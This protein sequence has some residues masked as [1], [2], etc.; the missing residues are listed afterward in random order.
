MQVKRLK[1]A[2]EC[3]ALLL[4]L[5][6]KAVKVWKD[7]GGLSGSPCLL[8]LFQEGW[9]LVDYSDEAISI[10]LVLQTLK[11]FLSLRKKFA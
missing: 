10:R 5:G 9:A 6:F 4:I 3:T 1:G 7:L 8:A 11:L 2:C